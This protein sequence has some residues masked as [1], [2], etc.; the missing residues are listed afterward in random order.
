MVKKSKRKIEKEGKV[1]YSKIILIVAIAVL[2]ISNIILFIAMKKEKVKPE[3][4]KIGCV[5]YEGAW[6]KESC[7]VKVAELTQNV[8]ICQSLNY[9]WLKDECFMKVGLAAGDDEL[10]KST[11]NVEK[12]YS[13]FAAAKQDLNICNKITT[14]NTKTFCYLTIARIKE[15]LGL[16]SHI[17]SVSDKDACYYGMAL[18]RLDIS[19]CPLISDLKIR[20]DCSLGVSLGRQ[21]ERLCDNINDASVMGFC[22]ENIKIE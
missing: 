5:D 2:I 19:V 1:D 8:S 16:C 10:C 17:S 11:S 4:T 13:D 3:Y 6:Q 14:A 18:R 22:Y 12:C 15:D 7:F 9:K 21:D 20:D